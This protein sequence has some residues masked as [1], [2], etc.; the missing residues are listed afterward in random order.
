MEKQLPKTFEYL[1]H[2]E[3]IYSKYCSNLEEYEQI[4]DNDKEIFM[5]PMLHL[6]EIIYMEAPA[7]AEDL[8]KYLCVLC[9]IKRLDI[10]INVK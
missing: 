4:S 5:N 10:E 7:W 1:N 3:D 2:M 6:A 9:Q 8:A